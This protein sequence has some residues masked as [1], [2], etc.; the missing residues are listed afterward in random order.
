MFGH[1]YFVLALVAVTALSGCARLD[2]DSGR[3]VTRASEVPPV[4]ANQR[5]SATELENF[6]GADIVAD[7]SDKDRAEA[8][9]A[10]FYAL[11][12]GRPGAP[13]SWQGDSGASGRV[14]VGPF[15]R[16]NALYCRDFSHLVTIDGQARQN[17]GTACRESDGSWKVENS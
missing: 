17:D 2:S 5:I 12:Y 4:A 13:R 6:V 11:Q 15:V 10:Q 16:V 3:A 7:M 8:I 1:K 9:S 14:S